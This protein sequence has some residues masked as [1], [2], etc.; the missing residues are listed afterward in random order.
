MISND[1]TN[2]ETKVLSLRVATGQRRSNSPISHDN[3]CVSLL[4][5]SGL[6]LSGRC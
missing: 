4:I 5:V 3:H 6:G 2:H 1:N